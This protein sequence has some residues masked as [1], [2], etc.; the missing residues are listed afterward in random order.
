[1]QA[2]RSHPFFTGIDWKA[3][4]TMSAPSLEAGLVKK[5]QGPVDRVWDDV[6]AAWD[7]MVDGGRDDD[8]ISWASDDERGEEFKFGKMEE[9]PN[10]GGYAEAVG[11]MGET[12]PYVPSRSI[13]VGSGGNSSNGRQTPRSSVGTNGANGV[14]GV[15]ASVTR[16][17]S[18]TGSISGV[19]FMENGDATRSLERQDKIPEQD[20]HEPVD[21]PPDSGAEADEDRDTVAATLDNVPLAVRTQP[22]DV[23]TA[24]SAIR[25]S[26]SA[27]SA[28]SSSD[29]SPPSAGLDAALA[30]AR[31]RNR[32]QTPIQ[33]NG[34]PHDDEEWY[35]YY[36]LS[37][38]RAL[39]LGRSQ[40]QFANGWGD[41]HLQR[42]GR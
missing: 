14:N 32:S 5:D 3:L 29:G 4:W 24:P 26:Y 27:G 25:E 21:E 7:E 28:T 35:V 9:M 23:P 33:G 2:L 17:G 13:S 39:T 37:E 42:L 34:K 31:G 15:K 10:G 41:C 40:V 19:R 30:A 12:R 38:D 1:M 20:R 16:S 18:G 6:G 22:I 36:L 11:P 8:E